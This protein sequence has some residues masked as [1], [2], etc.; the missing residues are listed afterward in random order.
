MSSVSDLLIRRVDMDAEVW[1]HQSSSLVWCLMGENP[2]CALYG[3]ILDSAPARCEFW[4]AFGYPC[5]SV[6][7]L[8]V[9]M[10]E[11]FMTR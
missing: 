10:E 11:W 7:V 2:F 9:D 6:D 1:R 5:S 4:I 8:F 3:S